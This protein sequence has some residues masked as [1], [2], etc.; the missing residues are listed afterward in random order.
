[1]GILGPDDPHEARA[2]TAWTRLDWLA[3]ASLPI[4]ALAVR[5][6]GLNRP[7]GLVFDEIFYAR[8]ACRYVLASDSACGIEQLA[9][10]AHP[11]LGNWLI[12][13]GI[14]VFGFEPFGWRIAAAIAGTLTVVLLFILARRLLRPIA[15]SRATTLGAFAAAGL[16]ATDF[17]HV[18]QSRVAM[19]DVFVTLFVVAAILFVV[20]DRDRPRGAPPSWAERLS[21]GHP[22]RLAAGASLGAATAV[23]WSGAYVGLA[24]IGLTV[25]WE[26]ASA[27]HETDGRWLAA[28]GRVLRR[29]ALPGVVLLGLVPVAVY[30][31]SYTGRMPG[32]LIGLPWQQGSVWRGIWDHQQ[33]MLDFHTK[34]AGDHPYE[35]PAWSWLLDKRPVAFWF[36]VDG[37]RYR[38]ILALGNPLVWWTGGVALGALA[39]RWAR[40]GFDHLRPEPVII[41]AAL[42]TY[43]PWLFLSGSRNETFIWYLLPTIPFL[44]LGLGEVAAWMWRTV[45]GR[46][47]A[48][49]FGVAVIASFVF[50]FP[51]LTALPL[52]PA[53]WRSRMLFTDCTRPTS[54]TLQLP[55]AE[56]SSGEPPTGW[57]WI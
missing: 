31:A 52:S 3:L 40:A 42:A 55:D 5:V 39:V 26:L 45:P 20:L 53:D 10:R 57:C 24:V 6:A 56:I 48:T 46:V 21:L 15:G 11:P 34:L 2:D 22:W 37:G 36:V 50:Y 7:L 23:K 32:E 8:N 17:L 51:L 54:P 28:I 27:L 13:T 25:A 12:A 43:A 16:L 49:A 1:M 19:L 44:C 14:K 33:A 38:E 29:E 41:A 47:A 35:S 9:S 18:A 4:G 30:L